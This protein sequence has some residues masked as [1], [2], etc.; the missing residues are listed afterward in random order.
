MYDS[1][2][3][4]PD[5]IE[6][7]MISQTDNFQPSGIRACND[8]GRN[9]VGS[10]RAEDVEG[11]GMNRVKCVVGNNGSDGEGKDRRGQLGVPGRDWTD[12]IS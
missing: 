7:K 9:W 10:E 5:R 6:G 4:P 2:A 12:D 3:G 1:S 8:G 11:D